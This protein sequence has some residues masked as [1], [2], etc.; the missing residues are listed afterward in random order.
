MK[1]RPA[2]VNLSD[3]VSEV[4]SIAG[5]RRFKLSVTYHCWKSQRRE[6]TYAAIEQQEV[7]AAAGAY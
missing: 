5:D 2:P 3:D 6:T 4:R 7:T 1:I